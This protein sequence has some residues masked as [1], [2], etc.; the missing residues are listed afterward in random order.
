[1]APRSPITVPAHTFRSRGARQS[2]SVGGDRVVIMHRACSP[3]DKSL[4]DESPP[5]QLGPGILLEH[6]RRAIRGKGVKV[7]L[8]GVRER[9]TAH[10]FLS[11]S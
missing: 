7:K 5:W 8:G 3:G 9:S 2:L 11:R 6:N 4:R 1:M 10:A